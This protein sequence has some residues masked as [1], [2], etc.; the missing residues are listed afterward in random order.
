[1]K[2]DSLFYWYNRLN[3]VLW[4]SE[5]L[6]KFLFLFFFFCTLEFDSRGDPFYL[7]EQNG[8]GLYKLAMC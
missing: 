1:M 6:I 7:K 4:V 3:S 5:H 2:L 8:S